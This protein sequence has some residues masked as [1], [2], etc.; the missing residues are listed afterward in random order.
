MGTCGAY[1]WHHRSEYAA[2]LPGWKARRRGH[3]HLE[4]KDRL[5]YAR[6]G[7]AV[8]QPLTNTEEGGKSADRERNG[9]HGKVDLTVKCGKNFRQMSQDSPSSVVGIAVKCARFCTCVR[10][11]DV[12]GL[13]EHFLTENRA[14]TWLQPG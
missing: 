8:G 11:A 1:L 2:A 12:P 7:L 10:S 3:R 5:A 14:S 9:T 4:T 6:F 13:S